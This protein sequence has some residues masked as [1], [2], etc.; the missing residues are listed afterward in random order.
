VTSFNLTLTP[1]GDGPPP[2]MRVRAL[3]KTA[4]RRHRL[5]CLNVTPHE[6]PHQTAQDATKDTGTIIESA[7]MPKAPEGRKNARKRPSGQ[8]L[9]V[10]PTPTANNPE[11]RL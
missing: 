5:R 9:T 1:V 2:K 10:M 8:R 7:A 3:L 4:L 11:R 6:K